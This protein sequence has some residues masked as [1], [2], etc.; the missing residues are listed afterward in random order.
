MLTPKALR[1][2]TEPSV[3]PAT[4]VAPAVRTAPPPAPAT[5]K[6]SAGDQNERQNPLRK[7][8]FY[9]AL[10]YIFVRLSVISELLLYIT[11]VNF[12]LLYIF[13]PPAILGALTTGG[14][15]RTLR[16]NAAKFWVGFF[17]WML[18]GTPFAS[19]RGE[20]AG[21]VLYYGRITLPILFVVAGLAMNWKEIRMV[22]YTIAGAAIF[23]L[24]T[25]QLFGRMD[26]EGRM[27]L[28]S[29]GNI[30]NS[31][32]LGAHLLLVLPFLLYVM[33]DRTRNFVIRIAML[34]PIAYG[35]WLVLGTAS[36]G[37]MLALGAMFLY[38]LYRAS[39]SQRAAAVIFGL[40]MAAT[41]PFLLPQNVRARLMTLFSDSNMDPSLAAEARESRSTR[42][43]L[44]RQ[45][46]RY[47]IEH[48]LFGVG[49]GDFTSY[50]GSE[51]LSKGEHGAWS[52]THNFLTQIS[53]EAGIPALLLVL[54]ALGSAMLAVNR[55][56]RA[57]RKKGLTDIANACFCYQLAMVGYLGSIIFLAQAYYYYLPMMVGLAVVLSAIAM[58]QM[59]P[60][61][62]PSVRA[63]APAFPFAVR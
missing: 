43:Y 48:P 40:V 54:M 25:A 5:A 31:N 26:D 56:Y 32:D 2:R 6:E 36:R 44:F 55:A 59:G 42:E 9:C 45:S 46:V 41:V 15:G 37:C 63:A 39:P 8:A 24:F 10:G 21:L 20:S 13:A 19:W 35:I 28:D 49:V 58:R 53:C 60:S 16:S 34:P 47:T 61:E 4:P 3:E 38:T 12:Y 7:I 14:I 1:P 50:E 22:F 52:V 18:I 62:S 33:L 17:I 27:R 51:S 30:G 11:H 23:S 57:A 29:S